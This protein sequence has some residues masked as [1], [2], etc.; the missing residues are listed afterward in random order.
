MNLGRVLSTF[1]KLIVQ[2][3]LVIT[4][5]AT[6]ETSSIPIFVRG[7]IAAPSCHCLMSA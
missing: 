5:V 7:Q 4:C 2:V 6:H 3:A 1:I